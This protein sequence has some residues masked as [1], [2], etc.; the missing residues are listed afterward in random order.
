MMM[1][2][3]PMMSTFLMSVLFA[4]GGLLYI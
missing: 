3:E 1:G 2:P 4:M